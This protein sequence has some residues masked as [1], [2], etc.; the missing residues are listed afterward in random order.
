MIKAR[1]RQ[2]LIAVTLLV[3]VTVLLWLN[4]LFLWVPLK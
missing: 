3:A 2:K 4:S 1:T